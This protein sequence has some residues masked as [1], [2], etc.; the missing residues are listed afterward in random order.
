VVDA[1]AGTVIGELVNKISRKKCA[2]KFSLSK[3]SVQCQKFSFGDGV[4]IGAVRRRIGL[5]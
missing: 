2:L 5:R 4:T 1:V 3:P